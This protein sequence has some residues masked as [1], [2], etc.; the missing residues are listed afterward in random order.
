M[1]VRHFT[2]NTFYPNRDNF[3][4]LLSGAADEDD[5]IVQFSSCFVCGRWTWTTMEVENGRPNQDTTLR[6]AAATNTKTYTQRERER[7]NRN[8]DS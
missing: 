3:G 1:D 4:E 5:D 7:V 8:C 6:S 2:I